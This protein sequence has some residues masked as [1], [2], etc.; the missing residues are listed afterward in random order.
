MLSILIFLISFLF[1]FCLGSLIEWFVHKDLMHSV[2]WMKTPHLRHA[3]EHHAERMAPGKYYAK[4]DELKEYHLFETSFM[5]ALWILHAPLF[6]A[7]YRFFGLASG[8]GVA[9]GTAV[10]V[11]AYEMLHWYMHCPDEFIFRNSRWFQYLSEHH[12]LHHNKATIN[13]NVVFPLADYLLGTYYTE[14]DIKREPE[15]VRRNTP[16]PPQ[17]R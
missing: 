12:R 9:M 11:I 5:P 4:D 10:Y 8:V 17:Q 1:A 14:L 15:D 16:L 6:F 2:Q 3:V 7:A 13:Y